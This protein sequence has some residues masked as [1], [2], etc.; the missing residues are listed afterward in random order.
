MWSKQVINPGELS[1]LFIGKTTQ[2]IRVSIK[3][4]IISGMDGR[5]EN[6]CLQE[7]ARRITCAVWKRA[8][9]AWEQVLLS[10]II[11]TLMFCFF[12]VWYLLLVFFSGPYWAKTVRISWVLILCMN[13]HRVSR[14]SVKERT[15]SQSTNLNGSGNIMHPEKVTARV[16]MRSET[17]HLVFWLGMSDVLSV[18]SG[19][20][21]TQVSTIIIYYNQLQINVVSIGI[22]FN[23]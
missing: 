16:T 19:G 15:M 7:K 22:K 18:I 3:I 12:F 11:Y 8:G 23:S 10:I 21:L 5:A 2:P 14:R 1:D 6:R 4:F 13:L 9:V 20:I 17:S